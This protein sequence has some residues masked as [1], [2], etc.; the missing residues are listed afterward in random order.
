MTVFRYGHGLGSASFLLFMPV[1]SSSPISL[2]TLSQNGWHIGCDG[3]LELS[4]YFAMP[5]QFLSAFR[6]LRSQLLERLGPPLPVSP[7]D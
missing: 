6:I 5:G 3:S 4:I 2:K 7:G 1:I